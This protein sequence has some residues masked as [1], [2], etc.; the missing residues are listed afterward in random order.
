[1]E[2]LM[3]IMCIEVLNAYCIP[4]FLYMLFRKFSVRI[5]FSDLVLFSLKFGFT[6]FILGLLKEERLILKYIQDFPLKL[7]EI[8]YSKSINTLYHEKSYYK[9]SHTCLLIC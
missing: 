5:F 2:N 6:I 4:I 7:W 1:M 8:Q 3:S 9:K